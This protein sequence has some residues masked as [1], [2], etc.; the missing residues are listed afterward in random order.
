MP[1]LEKDFEEE[2]RKKD[3]GKKR[4]YLY[5][6]MLI[7]RLGYGIPD[8]GAPIIVY[9]KIKPCSDFKLATR[10]NVDHPRTQRDKKR[11]RFRRVTIDTIDTYWIVS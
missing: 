5:M 3:G 2:K 9:D 6:N 1:W 10:K 4:D 11:D 7:W 8:I